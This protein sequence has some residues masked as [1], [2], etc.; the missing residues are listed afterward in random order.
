M[1]LHNFKMTRL[2]T[3]PTLGP[4]SALALSPVPR[5]MACATA[6]LMGL[7]AQAQTFK[8]P[9]LEALYVADK[10]ADLRRVSVQRVAAQPDDAQAVLGLAL[11]A[12]SLN[13]PVARKDA[14]ARAEACIARQPK[15][16]PCHYA[17]G[18]VLGVHAMSEGMLTMT[19]SAG[20]VRDALTTAHEIDPAWYPARGALVEFYAMA[21]GIMGGSTSK[22]TE[23]AKG[24]PRP[25]QASALQARILM[26]DQK[27]EPA[28]QALVALPAP[29]EP[30][31]ALDVQAWAV[32]SGLGMISKG[33]AAKAQPA[34]ERLQRQQPD[35]SGPAYGLARARA[36]QGA[37][38]DAIKLYEQAAGLKGGQEW[39]I[40]Y[41]IGIAQQ[42]L[43]R[44]DAAKA[45]L[46]RFVSAGKG[47]KSSLED[48]RKRLQQLGG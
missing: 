11:S 48:A 9:A 45:S 13:D 24:A 38:E 6:A 27:F 5:L 18:V 8:D 10:E 1:R 35:R 46:Q 3:T 34:F 40:A 4:I 17:Q 14:I 15:A 41:R 33:Q 7:T 39:P 32:Q 26:L 29:L 16:A 2:L 23:L 25:E 12:L 22:A 28:L 20:T 31:L 37:H 47:Q 30:A 44:N 19:R 21:P 42:Q 43:G 36:E